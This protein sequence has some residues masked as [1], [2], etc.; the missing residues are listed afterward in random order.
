MDTSATTLDKIE[1]I[2]RETIKRVA[3][4]LIPLL[5]LGYFCAYLDR[6]NVGMAAT[7]MTKDLGF[8]NAVFGFGAGVFFFG[9]FLFEIPSNLILNKMGAR[10]WI[11]RIL[12]TWGIIAALTG[13]A[14]SE[15]SFYWI[16]FFLGVAEAGFYPGVVLYLTWWFPSYYR[17]RM[18]SLFQS[19][20]VVSLFIGPP[21]GGLLLLMNGIGG[22]AGWQWLFIIEALPAIAM[23]VVMW[24]LLTDRPAQAE[25]LRPEQRTWLTERLASERAQQEAVRKFTLAGA[26][27]SRTLWLIT[28]A[29]FGNQMWSYGVS[30]FL[31]LI[32][33]GLGVGTNWIGLL[34]GLPYLAALVAMNYWGW[35]SDRTGERTWH[36]ASAWLLSSA[37][38]AACILVGPGYP[39]VVM[40]G[41][42]FAVIGPW[43]MAPA[44]WSLPS[45]LLTGTAAA[46]GI[47]MIGAVGQ[48]GSW[49]GPTLFGLVKDAT[50]SD[51]TAL[52]CLALAPV[53]STVLVVAAGHD[54]RME[55]IPPRA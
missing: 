50:G 37:G 45:A 12:I 41:L 22:L 39:A 27:S 34:S 7:T 30:F 16:R 54:R 31:P 36:V 43:A 40:V 4:R 14:W 52:L 6:S 28:I 9:Y 25:W 2:E 8:S 24:R 55:R 35:H 46:G 5:M 20:S 17:T 44:F 1:P 23:A 32:V 29:Y 3:W 11:A 51:T 10:R 38:M 42:T 33:K 19:A 47:A 15:W 18:M 13:F 48:L 49:F 21:I 53:I 26:F